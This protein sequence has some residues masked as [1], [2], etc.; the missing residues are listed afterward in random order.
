MAGK[1]KHKYEITGE[2]SIVR[3]T[4][5]IPGKLYHQFI[6]KLKSEGFTIQDGVTLLIKNYTEG[7][8]DIDESM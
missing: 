5:S 4:F 1:N 2:D 3:T 6:L 7:R 8:F